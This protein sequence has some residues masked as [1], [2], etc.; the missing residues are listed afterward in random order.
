MRPGR[1]SENKDELTLAEPIEVIAHVNRISRRHSDH[2]VEDSARRH[3]CP[4][5]RVYV[6]INL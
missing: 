4:R 6:W 5:V 1:E 2:D 3:C